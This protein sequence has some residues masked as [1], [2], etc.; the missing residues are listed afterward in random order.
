MKMDEYM[1]KMK[2]VPSSKQDEYAYLLSTLPAIEMLIKLV[3]RKQNGKKK[4][5]DEFNYDKSRERIEEAKK[6]ICSYL[7][8]LDVDVK[9]ALRD[10]S[11]I[12]RKGREEIKMESLRN[13]YLWIADTMEI[14][15][16]FVL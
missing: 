15:L 4:F 1:A 16:S 2:K 12:A 7:D 6:E 14:A 13:D 10:I 8:G 3:E 5:S 9:T 11:S